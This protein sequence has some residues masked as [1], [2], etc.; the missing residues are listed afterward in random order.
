MGFV[1]DIIG[2]KDS[3]PAPRPEPVVKKVVDSSAAKA[4]AKKRRARLAGA[5]GLLS[6][7]FKGYGDK[8]TLGG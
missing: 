7:G 2:G 8:D 5:K 4:R 1:A 3:P 6:G